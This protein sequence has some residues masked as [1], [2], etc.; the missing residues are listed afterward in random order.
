MAD[1]VEAALYMNYFKPGSIPT[2]EQIQ[3]FIEETLV[4]R[5]LTSAARQFILYREKRNEAR[6]VSAISGEWIPW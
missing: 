3:D 5:K 2:I 1:Q 6:E 4:L